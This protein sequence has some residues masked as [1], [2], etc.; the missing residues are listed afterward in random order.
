MSK[1]PPKSI[2]NKEPIVR[3]NISFPKSLHKQIKQ[4]ALDEEITINALVLKALKR[5]V[6]K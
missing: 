6:K 3:T 1:L 5:Y 2:K 4:C